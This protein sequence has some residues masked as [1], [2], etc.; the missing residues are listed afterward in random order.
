MDVRIEVSD[1]HELGEH[2]LGA[3]EAL[4]RAAFGNRFVDH[5]WDHILGGTHAIAIAGE[6]VVGHAAVVPRRMRIARQPVHVGY[7]EG[8]AV[9]ADVRRQRIG[10]RVMAPL[11]DIIRFEY[12]LG[13]LATSDGATA[14]YRSLGWWQWKGKTLADIPSGTVPTPEED[15]GIYVYRGRMKLDLNALRHE[16]LACDWRPGDLW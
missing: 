13:A 8:V 14:F 10:Q 11:H 12:D 16:D 5:D 3:V 7:V 2:Q 4:V 15:G 1:T 6:T 9:D